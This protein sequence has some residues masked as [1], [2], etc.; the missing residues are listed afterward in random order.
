[1]LRA[2]AVVVALAAVS[3]WL[4]PA[5]AG[6]LSEAH[7][8]IPAADGQRISV[9]ASSGRISLTTDVESIAGT[10]F[11]GAVY[12]SRGL[13]RKRRIRAHLGASAEVDVQFK[14]R[15]KPRTRHRSGCEI[16][17]RHGVFVGVAAYFG[18]AG[19]PGASTTRAPG[20]IE[21]GERCRPHRLKRPGPAGLVVSSRVDPLE[22]PT[23]S[24][25]VSRFGQKSALS[26]NEV[27]LAGRTLIARF[28]TLIAP[29]SA[30]TFNRRL[31][32]ATVQGLSPFSGAASFRRARRPRPW[33]GD[34]TAW[35]LGGNLLPLTG[36]GLKAELLR[37]PSA[38]GDTV[39]LSAER[40]LR[41]A[42][43]S[44][45]AAR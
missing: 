15:G 5:Q 33:R 30:F 14:P 7:F 18:E 31:T 42:R 38:G 34:L 11:D 28:T 19:A 27:S 9:H 21:T 44:A 10:R 39:T 29:R 2:V 22:A 13:V 35:L 1:M 20:R 41:L 3:V 26:A 23:Q 17:V 37:F 6:S 43:R 40:A 24:F 8:R 4:A 16:T 12:E 32:K 45:Q 36:V 25:V